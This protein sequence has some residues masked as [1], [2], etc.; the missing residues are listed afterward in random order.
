MGL[1]GEFCQPRERDGDVVEESSRYA[2]LQ[3]G[4]DDP[5]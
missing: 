3:E 5:T 1:V 4:E 2:L